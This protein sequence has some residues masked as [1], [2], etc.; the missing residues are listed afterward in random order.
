MP[1]ATLIVGA[2]MVITGTLAIVRGCYNGQLDA[3]FRSVLVLWFAGGLL[4]GT[5]L[6][7]VI[8]VT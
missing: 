2:I 5:G 6:I 4:T 3:S 7:L 1:I 8:R